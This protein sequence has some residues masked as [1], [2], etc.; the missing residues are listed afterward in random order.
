MLKLNK[1]LMVDVKSEL[2]KRLYLSI[3]ILAIA[4]FLFIYFIPSIVQSLETAHQLDTIDGTLLP[5]AKREALY[6]LRG[7]VVLMYL[8]IIT[9]YISGIHVAGIVIND[10]RRIYYILTHDIKL[11]MFDTE[12]NA[13]AKYWY[14]MRKVLRDWSNKELVIACLKYPDLEVYLKGTTLNFYSCGRIVDV[15]S[16]DEYRLEFSDTL[17]SSLVTIG[18]REVVYV[19]ASN[20]KSTN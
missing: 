8:I 16:D 2:T 6:F 15:L 3:A 13:S 17:D 11:F 12:T 19:V 10:C 20:D 1:R 7:L 18:K 9:G 4:M 5:K 14:N